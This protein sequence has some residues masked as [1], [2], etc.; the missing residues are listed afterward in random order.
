MPPHL[1]RVLALAGC[2]SGEVYL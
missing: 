2:M 1:Q